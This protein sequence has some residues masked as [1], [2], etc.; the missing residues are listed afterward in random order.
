VALKKAARMCPGAAFLPVDIAAYEAASERFMAL[1]R[2]YGPLVE[3]FGLDE[4]FIEPV[5]TAATADP[6]AAGV[7]IAREIRSR[8]GRELGLAASAGVGPNKLLARMACE[9]AKPDGL[10]VISA[11]D[12]DT[13]LGPLPIARLWGVSRRIETRLMELGLR[14]IG[15]VARTPVEHLVRNFGAAEGRTLHEHARGVDNSP[16]VPFAGP[17]AVSREVT[18]EAPLKD[19]RLVRE[20]LFALTEDVVARLKGGGKAA[21]AVAIKVRFSDFETV[22][23]SAGFDETTASPNTVRAAVGRLMDGVDTAKA[24]LLVGVMLS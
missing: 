21:S 16:V 11:V 3:S 14:T 15:E 12:M 18:F 23:R 5:L 13:L 10:A 6:M 19:A 2:E 17:P 9:R 8:A 24:V 1:V 4:V 22:T 20:T 7:E